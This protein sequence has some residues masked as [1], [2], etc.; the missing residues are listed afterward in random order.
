MVRQS[1]PL[2]QWQSYTVKTM[3]SASLQSKVL[4]IKVKNQ[5]GFWA[6]NWMMVMGVLWVQNANE[7]VECVS[8]VEVK[9]FSLAQ[10]GCILWF[11]SKGWEALIAQLGECQTEVLKVL[12]LIHSQSITK[13]MHQVNSCNS[14]KMK[15]L[16]RMEVK[17]NFSFCTK[18]SMNIPW[19][20]LGACIR[21]SNVP[22]YIGRR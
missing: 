5:N 19:Y 8:D 9:K 22:S 7:A 11:A 21:A 13:Q 14:M 20:D 17:I 4:L 10:D 18:S 1:R 2:P 16:L 6:M 3:E 15:T 12:C